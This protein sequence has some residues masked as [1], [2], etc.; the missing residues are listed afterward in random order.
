MKVSAPADALTDSA[1]IA[2]NTR[3]PDMQKAAAELAI[4]IRAAR[5]V[6]PVRFMALDMNVNGLTNRRSDVMAANP[7]RD[8]CDS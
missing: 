1:T 8:G 2:N 7:P 4:I 3:K 5:V 6:A